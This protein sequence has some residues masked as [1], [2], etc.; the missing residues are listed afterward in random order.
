V[1]AAFRQQITSDLLAQRPQSVELLVVDLRPATYA[2]FADFGQP[3]R[4]IAFLGS[5]LYH[6]CG[7]RIWLD[8]L[9][10]PA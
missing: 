10:T 3:F 8:I 1:F 7:N 6:D 4:A 5:N 9:L 2:S